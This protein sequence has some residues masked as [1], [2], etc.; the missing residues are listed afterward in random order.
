M[1]VLKEN[2]KSNV[3]LFDVCVGEGLTVCGSAYPT[4]N[5]EEP[6]YHYV[7]DGYLWRVLATQCLDDF[8]PFSVI[9]FNNCF[10]EIPRGHSIIITKERDDELSEDL[11]LFTFFFSPNL[12]FW[13][14]GVSFAEY[15]TEFGQLCE[16][17]IDFSYEFNFEEL[18]AIRLE[19]VFDVF[20]MPIESILSYV[21]KYVEEIHELTLRTLR[22]RYKEVYIEFAFSFPE[23]LKIACTQ[24][25]Q[26]F[27]QFLTD[28]GLS[29]TSSLVDI[30]EQLFLTV[31][32]TDDAVALER[33]KEALAIYLQL[34][35][36]PI[37][38]EN[39]LVSLRLRQQIEHF[40]IS[41]TLA[42]R[43]L[44]SSEELLIAQAGLIQQ[45]DN[46]IA[47]LQNL[48]YTQAQHIKEVSHRA[49]LINS[50]DDKEELIRILEGLEI[51]E[52]KW[53][54]EKLGI[55]FNPALCLKSITRSILGQDDIISLQLNND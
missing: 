3:T 53:L 37:I 27:A 52:S 19:M 13:V 20:S 46:A 22:N 50:A 6:K 39:R 1:I 25:L 12:A 17:R 28:L 7:A 2:S 42:L 51:G 47:E 16:D 41:Q 54:R 10:S 35:S 9:T 11:I 14:T 26:Y 18:N 29:A 24:Y 40:Q 55:R 30:K 38:Y 33:I 4:D 32:P 36:S 48:V 49:I 8:E 34:P 45:K 43:E 44:K 5:S 31:V 15:A 23:S 21:R